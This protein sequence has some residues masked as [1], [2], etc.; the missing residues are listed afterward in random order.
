[1]RKFEYWIALKADGKEVLLYTKKDLMSAN[2]YIERWSD[3]DYYVKVIKKNPLKRER[4]VK[5]Q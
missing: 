3:K 1:M 2:K 5:M 4:A